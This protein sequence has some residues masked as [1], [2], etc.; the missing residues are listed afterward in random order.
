[1]TARLP[2]HDL[3][4]DEAARSLA[5]RYGADPRVVLR[6]LVAAARI[7]VPLEAFSP[8]L[9]PLENVILYLR[10]VREL[11]LAQIARVVGRDPRSV[12][13]AYHRAKRK[14]PHARPFAGESVYAFPVDLLRDHRLSVAEHVVTH[15]RMRYRLPIADIA[16]LLHRDPRTVGTLLRRA[17]PRVGH[18]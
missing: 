1:M 3:L 13:I 10:D 9:T 5:K 4:L 14:M 2:P 15:V 8:E 16:R 7:M 18:R 11:P 6:E 12:G 17:S